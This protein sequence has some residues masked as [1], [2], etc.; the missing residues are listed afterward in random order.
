MTMEDGHNSFPITIE[1][2]EGYRVLVVD[3]EDKPYNWLESHP[4]K[5]RETVTKKIA[6][7]Y[8]KHFL[9]T[10]AEQ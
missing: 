10:L 6:D 5:G 7:K 2:I 4:F 3:S 9:D 8:K 1:P